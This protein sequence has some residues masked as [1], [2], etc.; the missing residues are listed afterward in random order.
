MPL[1]LAERWFASRR[2]TPFQFQRDCWRAYLAG[3]S[4]LLHAPT[5]TGKTLA[6]WLGPILESIRKDDLAAHGARVIWIT[7]LRALAGD[8]ADALAEAASALG[9]HW[10]ID[11][12]TGD[13][14]S[15][16]KSLQ[17]DRPP[18]ALVTTPESLSILMSYEDWP[19]RLRSVRCVVVDEWHELLGTKRG[20]QT[21]LALARLRAVCPELRTWGVSATLGN[22]EEAAAALVGTNHSARIVRGAAP[23]RVEV[24][25]LL[26]ASL[27]RFPW[28]GHIGT[29][30]AERA[31][32]AIDRAGTTLLFTNTRSQAEIWFRTLLGMRPDLLGRIA[33]HHGSLDQDIRAEIER[34]LRAGRGRESSL[35]CVVCTSSLDLGVDFGPV[36]QVIQVGS[37]KGVARFVQRA[38][39]SGHRPGAPSRIVCIPSN[40]LELIEFAA[41][42]D[43]IE[44]GEL[45]SRPPLRKPLDVLAQ[46]L[47]TAGMGG[48]FDASELLQEVR[49]TYAFAD[50]T[51]EEWGWTLDFVGRGGPALTAY[52]E[53]ARVGP[54]ED[55]RWRVRERRIATLHRMGI[56]TIVA[57]SAVRVQY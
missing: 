18:S 25:T 29:A 44:A 54:G 2:W 7:P 43:A 21:E 20:V 32:D 48:G 26:P 49:T 51:D 6:V 30:L 37:P 39:R 28:S 14:P 42:R 38:G 12:R 8:T 22:I 15:R 33:L 24:E 4:G 27:D 52:P 11:V 23:K 50:L 13:T 5:G 9:S 34:L 17:R 36:D 56:G 1:D 45:E 19:A 41:A 47:V 55:G 40:A 46:H 31:L 16:R 3:E 53:Y 10:T 57:D 35:R